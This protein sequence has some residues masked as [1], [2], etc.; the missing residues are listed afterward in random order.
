MAV[1]LLMT[2]LL[3]HFVAQRT[4]VSGTSMVPTLESGDQ[5]IADK[6]SYRF[7][8]PERFDIIVFPW[9][10]EEKT[11]F[12][13]RVIGLPG[14]RVLIDDD[15]NIYIDGE[16]LEE[17]YGKDVIRDPGVAANEIQLADDEYFVL[18]DNREVS[19]DSRSADVGNI[20]RSDIIGR[21]WIRIYP[22]SEFGILKHQ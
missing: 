6:I 18:G 16:I 5:L 3:V 1:V 2:F 14:E 22:F 19:K 21:A 4:E 7:R 20:R 9:K 13:K 15:G 12:I 17:D 10:F 8:D 11:F